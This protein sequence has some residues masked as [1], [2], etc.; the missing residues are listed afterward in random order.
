MSSAMSSTIDELYQLANAVEQLDNSACAL[1]YKVEGLVKAREILGLVRN[2]ITY[3]EEEF[4]A[5]AH[6]A[7]LVAEELRAAIPA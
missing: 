2:V 4:T 7:K 5:A 6:D 1:L 3:H